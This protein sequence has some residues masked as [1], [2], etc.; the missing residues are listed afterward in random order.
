[1]THQEVNKFSNAYPQQVS[2]NQLQVDL[3]IS[4]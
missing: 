4:L 3:L 2:K 1:M